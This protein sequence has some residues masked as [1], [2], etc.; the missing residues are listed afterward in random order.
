MSQTKVLASILFLPL[1]NVVTL[2]I[3][4]DFVGGY[5]AREA[6]ISG[7]ELFEFLSFDLF[8]RFPCEG[9]QEGLE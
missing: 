2:Y 5:A 1:Q 9:S 4:L 6:K 7:T 8:N 3:F